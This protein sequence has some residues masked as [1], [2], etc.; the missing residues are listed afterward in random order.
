MAKV[1]IS[2][3]DSLLAALDAEAGRRQTTRSGLL[4][5]AA[6][7]EVGLL[8]RDRAEILA[9]LD[10]LGGSWSGPVDAAALVRADRER[11]G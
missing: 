11:D 8:R 3:P 2:M 4:Q 9:D 6:R 10:A 7:R 1:M 5:D